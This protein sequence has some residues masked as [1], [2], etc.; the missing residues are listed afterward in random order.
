ML[1]YVESGVH[2]LALRTLASDHDRSNHHRL[3]FSS[4]VETCVTSVGEAHGEWVGDSM[5]VEAVSRNLAMAK[6]TSFM[7]GLKPSTLA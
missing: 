6:L 3:Y 2:Y 7:R 4:K 1:S 5:A